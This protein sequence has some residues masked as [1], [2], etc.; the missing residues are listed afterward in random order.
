MKQHLNASWLIKRER[1]GQRWSPATRMS[2]TPLDQDSKVTVVDRREAGWWT[3]RVLEVVAS[4]MTSSFTGR[5]R[6][7]SEN[8][9][10]LAFRLELGL[11][12][13]RG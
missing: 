13:N 4:S 2:E 6:M 1:E 7:F 3:R 11:S 8:E 10:I 12:W 5:A 9:D